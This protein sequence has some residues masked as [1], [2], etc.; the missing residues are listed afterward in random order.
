M[1]SRTSDSSPTQTIDWL[2][3]HLSD[4]RAAPPPPPAPL[5]SANPVPEGI[6]PPPPLETAADVQAV[7]AWLQRERAR[8]DAYT[9]AQ[10]NRLQQENQAVVS[11]HYLNEQALILRSQ[12]LSRK[13]ELLVQQ[14]HSLQQQARELSDREQALTGQLS[15]WWR[16]QEELAAIQEVS[17]TVR[18]DL[19]SQR[20]LLQ[21]VQAET[22]ALLKARQSAEADLQ[23][24]EMALR[25][26]RDAR[27]R[28]EALLAAR[29]SQLEQR[30]ADVDRAEQA[31]QRRVGE[32][33]ELEARLQQELEAQEKHLARERR[34]LADLYAWVREQTYPVGDTPPERRSRTERGS[35]TPC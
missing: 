25:E 31:V 9:R 23:T 26:Q 10:L 12:E 4:G 33:D 16:G 13:E 5:P 35:A 6:Q 22:A 34:E 29:R 8:L 1:T 17:A 15:Q 2:F 18:G 21:T 19:D 24:L 14:S 30:L 32:L 28:E 3:S 27:V 7:H 20:A 11:Q